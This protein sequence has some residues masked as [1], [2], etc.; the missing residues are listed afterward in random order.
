MIFSR[1]CPKCK[2][3]IFHKTENA[4]YQAKWSDRVCRSCSQIGHR[5]SDTSKKKMSLAKI[6]KPTWSSLHRKEFG[7]RQSGKN[8]PMYGK[9][10]TEEMRRKQSE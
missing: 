3:V 7:K 10:H 4:L 6:G 2:S 1:N 5:V 8:H 9:H